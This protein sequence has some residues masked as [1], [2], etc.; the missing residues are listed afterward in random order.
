MG[1]IIF[2][3]RARVTD[4]GPGGRHRS[5]QIMHD[6]LSH[7][8]AAQVHVH[9]L[10]LQDWREQTHADAREPRISFSELCLNPLRALID[11]G[12]TQTNST[13][14]GF[15]AHYA[16]YIA[17][18][19]QPLIAVVDD[20]RLTRIL[21]INAQRSIPTILC[22]QNLETLD[23]LPAGSGRVRTRAHLLDFAAETDTLRTLAARLMISKTEAGFIS[24]LGMSAGYYPYLPAGQIGARLREIR[25]QRAVSKRDR[26]RGLFLML[27]SAMHASTRHAF[28]HLVAQMRTHGLPAAMRIVLAGTGTQHIDITGLRGVEAHGW[29]D[30][31]ELDRL[32]VAAQGVLVPQMHG[33][34]A[35]TR[36]SEMACAGIPTLTG[37]HAAWAINIP[38]GVQLVDDSWPT[39]LRAMEQIST[40]SPEVTGYDEWERAQPRPLASEIE[41]ILRER[42]TP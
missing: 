5:Y 10:S 26:D 25:M 23:M 37:R 40:Q 27:G 35:V 39:W 11:T 31:A 24:S 18:L 22:P 20:V 8:G 32:L 17:T 42:A 21:D 38:P 1:S 13:P 6:L 12:Y 14:H 30:Q 4:I 41:H 28:E 33:F 19:P 16:A 9:V 7:F 3:T 2:I 36:I 29:I 15:A 34:G